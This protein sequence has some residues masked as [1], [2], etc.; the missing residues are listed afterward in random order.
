MNMPALFCVL[1]LSGE[2]IPDLFQKLAV[3]NPGTDPYLREVNRY[4]RMEE[5]RHLAFARMLLPEAWENAGRFQRYVV[6]RIA[7]L[8]VVTMFDIMVNPDVY[9]S[10]GLPTW[11]TWKQVRRLPQRK[12][13]R[14]Q[15]LRP[16]LGALIEAGVPRKGRINKRWQFAAGV[17]RL[18]QPLPL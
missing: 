7:P 5:A 8:I 14:H 10:V 3:E 13:L 9:A 2:E 12:A 17:D 11:E 16:L 4:H 15:S 1:V 6:R 18:G